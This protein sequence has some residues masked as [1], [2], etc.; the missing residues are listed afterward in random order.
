M[1]AEANN[2]ICLG[3]DFSVRGDDILVMGSD[4]VVAG[5]KNVVL[6]SHNRVTGKHNLVIGDHL[7]VT[8]DYNTIM[9]HDLVVVGN[10]QNIRPDHESSVLRPQDVLGHLH[11]TLMTALLE[12]PLQMEGVP[13]E[14]DRH[15]LRHM[16]QT[17]LDEMTASEE[18]E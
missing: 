11:L 18:G 3:F 15:Q 6:G 8:G 10:H 13:A 14:Y 12:H 9:G 4:S 16:L 5:D 1:Q 2:S 17:R 7:T